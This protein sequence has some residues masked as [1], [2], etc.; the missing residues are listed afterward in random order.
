MDAFRAVLLGVLQGLTEF[1]PVSSSGHLVVVPALLGWPEPGLAFDTILHL[2]TLLAVLV[3]FRDDWLRLVRAGLGSLGRRR[4]ET[5]DE[6]Q[7]WL[8]VLGCVPAALAGLLLEEWFA[9]VFGS[10]VAVGYFLLVTAALLVAG[11]AIGR[12]ER[13]LTKLRL[14]D[15]LAI[16]LAQAVA[17][18]PGVSRAGATISA[19]LLLG[20]DRSAAARFSFLLAAPI[21][22]GAGLT[23][24]PDALRE[25]ASGLGEL[26]LGFGAAAV[27]GYLCIG[28]LLRYLRRG[29][30]YP[31]A[32]YCALIGVVTIA[33]LGRAAN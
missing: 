10:P 14:P 18:L 9:G 22:L 4:I 17:I 28:F 19:G 25:H 32:V 24:L 27:T 33:A 11:E 1:I 16:G 6:W 3:Y 8:V 20:L 21:I 29:S 5:P 23:Q 31:F 26:A 12:R 2:G 7:A 13:D 15:A 30:L